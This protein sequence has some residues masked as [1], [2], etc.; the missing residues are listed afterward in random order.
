MA[1]PP[2]E[3]DH[4]RARTVTV[5]AVVLI[6]VLVAVAIGFGPTV[7]AALVLRDAV[8]PS[9][10]LAQRI[11]EETVAIGPDL[12]ARLY[13]PVDA[14]GPLPAI[15][16][17]HGAIGQGPDDPRLVDL[18]RALADRGA[19]VVAPRLDALAR[20]RLDPEDPDR[21][22]A[23]V[24][25][26]ASRSDLAL[27][28]QVAL[29]GVSIGGTYGLLASV[30][31][32]TAPV[33]SAVMVFGGYYDLSELLTQWLTEPVTTPTVLDPLREGR[34][35]VLLGNVEG[36]VDAEDVAVV[37]ACLEALVDDR[38]CRA[39]ASV[40]PRGQL[41]IE[42]ARSES[43]LEPALAAALLDPMTTAMEEL[44]P[45]RLNVAP[46]PPI[47]LLHAIG[48]PVVSTADTERVAAFLADLGADVSVHI[49]GAFD[50][51]DADSL[52]PLTES[53]PLARFVSRF[54][55]D[56]GLR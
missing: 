20:F 1:M 25:W 8:D 40:G 24:Q 9:D 54:L 36:S 50:H 14:D 48:D 28:G 42:A 30:D 45:S 3:A 51:V 18:H 15:V 46:T 43:P 4:V 21:V 55:A 2:G 16:V 23:T 29:F 10:D 6:V 11:H 12:S 5:A 32:A 22:A 34:R 47:Y 37:T 13:R 35:L 26:L 38:P 44:S 41:F 31:E 17:V 33:V 53:W 49:T 27:D 56:S 7:R 19:T 52:P 39:D